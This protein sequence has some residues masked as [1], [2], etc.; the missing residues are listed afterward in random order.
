[1]KVLSL[2]LG[3]CSLSEGHPSLSRGG[4]QNKLFTFFLM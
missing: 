3:S 1:M 2:H 4:Y